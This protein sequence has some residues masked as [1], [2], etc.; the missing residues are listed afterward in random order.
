MIP[1]T[2]ERIMNEWGTA[3]HNRV[4]LTIYSKRNCTGYKIIL[5]AH[6]SEPPG[7]DTISETFR[8]ET[9]DISSYLK[10]LKDSMEGETG[11]EVVEIFGDK[12]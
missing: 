3:D 5:A 9:L 4:S 7:G 12:E 6:I 8:I 2:R 10:G 11:C 1:I